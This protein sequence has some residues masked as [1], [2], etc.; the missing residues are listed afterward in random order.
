MLELDYRNKLLRPAWVEVDL[1]AVA[2]N[3]RNIKRYLQDVKLLAVVK[4][5][6][7]GLGAVVM[8]QEIFKNGAD[9]LGVVML[10]EA[11]ELRRA[12]ITAPI[13][14]SGPIYPEQAAYVPTTLLQVGSEPQPLR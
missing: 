3:V 14:N 11:Y 2:F 5:N 4:A 1:D 8:A 7:Y 12:G 13:L 10:D 6:G 9:Y